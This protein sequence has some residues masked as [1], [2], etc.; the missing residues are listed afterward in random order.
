MLDQ[1][2][3]KY[4]EYCKKYGQ[5]PDYLVVN[6]ELFNEIMTNDLDL[7]LE[8]VKSLVIS[9]DRSD[10][11]FYQ[12]WE[13]D[14]VLDEYKKNNPRLESHA[15]LRLNRIEIR[16]ISTSSNESVAATEL[17]EMIEIDYKTI[18]AY[19]RHKE[20]IINGRAQNK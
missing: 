19:Q 16:R 7:M 4:D 6:H 14:Y 1:I 12:K 10:F 5:R 3:S 20:M 17:G 18:C 2:K 15:V 13:L 11:K 8:G 9:S